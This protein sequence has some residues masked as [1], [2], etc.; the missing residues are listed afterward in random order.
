MSDIIRLLPDSVAN[1]IAAG[2]VIQEPASI[3]KELVENSI[4]AGATRIDVWVVDAGKTCVQVVDNGKGMSEIDARLCF[5][6]HATSKITKATDLYALTTMGFRGEA[7]ASVAAVAQVELKTKTEEME[8]G[9]SLTLEHSKVV[10]QRPVA[11][12][13]GTN[14]SVKNLFFNVPAR[15]KFL[16]SDKTEMRH[17]IEAFERIVLTTPQVA[18]TLNNGKA[19]VYDLPAGSLKQRISSVFGKRVEKVLLPLKVETSTVTIEGFVSLP[20]AAKAKGGQQYF[21]VNNRY[22]NH[23]YFRRAVQT[24]YERL[25]PEGYQPIFFLYLRVEPSQIDVNVHPQKTEIKFTDEQIIFQVLQA[26]TRETLSKYNAIPS[27]DFDTTDR[28]NIPAYIPTTDDFPSDFSVPPIDSA[29]YDPFLGLAIRPAHK[30]VAMPRPT[31]Y[32]KGGYDELFKQLATSLP[33][34][35]PEQGK[36]YVEATPINKEAWEQMHWE[37]VQL[38]RQY[39]IAPV[40]QGLLVVDQVRAHRRILYDSFMRKLKANDLQAQA[41]IFPEQISLSASQHVVFETLKADLEAVGFDF[42]FMGK[43]S[44]AIN[45]VP[46]G[47]EGIN[48]SD[49]VMRMLTEAELQ[50]TDVR[51]DICH[52]I[53]KTLAQRTAITSNQPLQPNDMGELLQKL[54]TCEQP[55]TSP[56]GKPIFTTLSTDNLRKLLK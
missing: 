43:G 25:I 14:L 30:G 26:A 46:S 48:A 22:M 54:F 34:S 7:L 10:D 31:Q 9:V 33:E 29:G 52:F 6:R 37:C 53:G 11:S 20:E 12:P 51:E 4:D 23:P 45:A 42:S 44:Y 38:D 41:V 13:T 32:D 17:V 18:F 5:E 39:I 3:V 21:F 19:N 1:Q 50:T 56:D 2:E 16:R 40:E 47:T 8:V 49:L 55:N 27:I 35:V 15:R 28:P 24:A 36:L